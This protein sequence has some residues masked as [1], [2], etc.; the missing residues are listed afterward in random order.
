LPER[1]NQSRK[2]APAARQARFRST[3]RR[4]PLIGSCPHRRRNV[5]CSVRAARPP[6]KEGRR[7]AG[8]SIGKTA[9]TNLTV[10]QRLEFRSSTK[11]TAR[12]GSA[13]DGHPGLGNVTA[14]TLFDEDGKL[15]RRQRTSSARTFLASVG[16]TV[17]AAE[18]DPTHLH[19]STSPTTAPTVNVT[20]SETGNPARRCRAPRSA[21]LRPRRS[22][23]D[24]SASV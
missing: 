17:A 15:H 14:S 10:S 11:I 13:W 16:A 3:S 19:T 12:C 5:A 20:V 8:R 2:G 21:V 22:S 6:R 9:C 7:N 18:R 1:H 4:R 24:T 23:T